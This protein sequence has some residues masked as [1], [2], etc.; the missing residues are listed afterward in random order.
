MQTLGRPPKGL[1]RFNRE[2]RVLDVIAV[3][4]SAPLSLTLGGVAYAA[5]L[6]AVG[7]PVFYT[8]RRLGYL[9]REFQLL[10]FRTMTNETDEAGRLLSDAERITKFG[11]FLR[12][13]SLDELPQLINVL[14]G[15]MSLVG[16]RP[17]FVEYRE[18]YLPHE[19]KRHWVRP[20]ITGLAQT[21][22]RNSLLWDQRLQLDSEYVERANL[23]EDIRILARTVVKVL[24]SSEVSAVAGETGEPLDVVR[25]YPRLK[26]YPL[27]R[28][29]LVDIPLRVAWFNDT[30]MRKHMELPENV[31]GNSARTWIRN[32]IQDADLR[33]FD[34]YET[35]TGRVVAM[36]L[37]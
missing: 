24:G 20:G 22:G 11:S 3:L 32:A 14:R 4:V 27:R 8:Q 23:A 33:E 15:D 26:G 6:V 1:A 37:V 7:R 10:K 35:A 2:K 18:H 28:L 12:K 19:R 5:A 9:E 16:P 30:N 13:T 21:S 34:V 17:L 31:I 36:V 29:E 25:S